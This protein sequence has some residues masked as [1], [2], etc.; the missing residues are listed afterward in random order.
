M[1]ADVASADGDA[2]RI[3]ELL[4]I[5]VRCRDSRALQLLSGAAVRKFAHEWMLGGRCTLT[6]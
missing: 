3:D 4:S 2:L 1:A 6:S 5:S